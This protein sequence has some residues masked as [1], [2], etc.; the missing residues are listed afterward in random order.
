MKSTHWITK[1][2]Q[3]FLGLVAP[4]KPVTS[5]LVARW[6]KETIKEVGLGEGFRAH[7]T[8]GSAATTAV[9]AGISV[10][11][12]MKRAGWSKEYTFCRYY[13]RP[14]QAEE[15]ACS[16]TKKVLDYKHA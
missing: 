13:Y 16:F 12:I 3:L 10:Q 4:H 6:L 5:S 1:P 2:D 7:T 11:E 14:S 15:T 9:M 8:R